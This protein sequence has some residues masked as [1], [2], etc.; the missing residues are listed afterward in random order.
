MLKEARANK[1]AGTRTEACKSSLLHFGN[2]SNNST[3]T[4]SKEM[5]NWTTLILC[6]K[7]SFCAVRVYKN[8]SK[9]PDFLVTKYICPINL[10][11]C[12]H[13][14]TISTGPTL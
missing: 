11:L 6:M 1:Q 12:S 10:Y 2:K 14:S 4:I 13:I 8:V 7:L 3:D 5:G 9:K